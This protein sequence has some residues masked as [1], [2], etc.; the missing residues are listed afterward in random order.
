MKQIQ[1]STKNNTYPLWIGSHILSKMEEYTTSYD[2]ILFFT[3]KT[4]WN[5]YSSFWETFLKQ[6]HVFCYILED[7]EE[8]KNL[9]SISKV[10]DFMIEHHF[11]RKSHRQPGELHHL[12]MMRK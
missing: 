9:S 4:L 7:G 2:K 6:A 3:N 12:L 5:L 11:S 8:Y 10:Y 1:I